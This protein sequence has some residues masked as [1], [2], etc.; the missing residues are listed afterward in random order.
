MRRFAIRFKENK[1]T[2]I[3][4]LQDDTQKRGSFRSN[5]SNR[6]SEQTKQVRHSYFDS[7]L[8][9]LYVIELKKPYSTLKP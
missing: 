1:L 8:I 2:S 5:V 9:L 6:G 3:E 4:S 7:L